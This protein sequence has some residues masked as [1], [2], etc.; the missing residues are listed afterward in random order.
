METWFNT[1]GRILR[2]QGEALSWIGTPFS[3]NGNTKGERGGTSCQTLASE[4]YSAAGFGQIEVPSVMMSHARFSRESLVAEFMDARPEFCSVSTENPPIP[5]DL[6]GFRIHKTVHH[7]GVCIA[8]GV[9][10]HAL[11]GIGVSKSSLHDATY[12]N[13]LERIWRPRP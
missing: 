7:V 1:E 10:I 2:L 13:R 8:P 11:E 3:P 5:G 12:S 4:I 6:L 9:F